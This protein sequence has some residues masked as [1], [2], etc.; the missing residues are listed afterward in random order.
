VKK[1]PELTAEELAC[2]LVSSK[3]TNFEVAVWMR[4]DISGQAIIVIVVPFLLS[5][6]WA[7]KIQ[8]STID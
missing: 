4:E 5:K 7:L 6:F 1:F 3:S 8:N 2:S